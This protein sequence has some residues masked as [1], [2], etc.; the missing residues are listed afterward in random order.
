MKL[1]SEPLQFEWDADKA[2]SNVIKHRVTFFTATAIF[3][4]EVMDWVDD[5]E[6][7]GEIRMIAIG[8]V[9]FEIFEIV[10]TMRGMNTVRIISARKASKRD[11]ERYYRQILP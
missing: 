4:H 6:D 1:T 9:D 5:R 3:E 2:R 10:Y 8:R 7:Y 11:R